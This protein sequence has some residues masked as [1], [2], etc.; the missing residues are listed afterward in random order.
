VNGT[1]DAQIIVTVVD[2]NG[3]AINNCPP[4]TLAIESGPGEFPTGPSIT[5][6]PDSDI[7]IRDG[8]AAIEFRS[9][10][11]GKTVIRATSP[12]LKDATIQITS[13]G[14]PKFIPGQTPSVKPRP[15]VR[16]TGTAANSSFMILGRE[17]P[18]RASSETAGHSTHFAKDGNAATFWQA[19]ANDMKAWLCIDLECIVTVSSVKL[20]FPFDGNWRYRVEISDDGNGGWKSISDQS[21]NAKSVKTQ[22]LSAMSGARG[23]FL[24]V[25]FVGTPDAKPAALVEVEVLSNVS[26]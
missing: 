13:Q 15:Y 12:G 11:A 22:T 20:S 2:K 6:A 16:F 19:D 23:R 21:Q 25:I 24:R 14:E 10:S 5:F 9:Y 1:D 3:N 26:R 4:V 18:T 7:V 8:Q 17:N